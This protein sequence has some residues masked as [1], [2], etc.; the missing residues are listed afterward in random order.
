MVCFYHGEQLVIVTTQIML[1]PTHQYSPNPSRV[2]TCLI[3][4]LDAVLDVAPGSHPC[5]SE[6]APLS[7]RSTWKLEA[8]A[9]INPRFNNQNMCLKNVTR[10]VYSHC[11]LRNTSA[12]CRHHIHQGVFSLAG[13]WAVGSKRIT[14]HANLP[15]GWFTDRAQPLWKCWNVAI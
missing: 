15:Q 6:H 13:Q 4:L 2:V 8:E 11:S 3:S 9:Q 14:P 12:I 10:I 5:C 1:A 7:S